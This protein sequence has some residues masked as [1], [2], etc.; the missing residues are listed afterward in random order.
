MIPTTTTRRVANI[1]ADKLA[2]KRR[3]RFPDM[4]AIFAQCSWQRVQLVALENVV[5]VPHTSSAS[6]GWFGVFVVYQM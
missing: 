1:E 5:V 6:L 4:L 2:T 3:V